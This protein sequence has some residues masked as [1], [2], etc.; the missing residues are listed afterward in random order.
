MLIDM[1]VHT[2]FSPCSSLGVE[3]ILDNA[4]SLG[5]DGVCLTD[6]NSLEVGKHLREGVQ[7]DGLVVL[8]GQE[9]ATPSGDFL[10][11][12]PGRA[13]P[14]GLRA[15]QLLQYVTASGGA[16]VAAHPFRRQRPCDSRVLHHPGIAA[17]E[18]INGRC[19]MDENLRALSWSSPRQMPVTGGS[20]AHSLEELARAV[21]VFEHPVRSQDE[22]VRALNSGAFEA[23]QLHDDLVP[24]ACPAPAPLLHP[25]QALLA[26]ASN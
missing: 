6:H 9:Y 17:I 11:F 20:D 1:H 21:T 8:V 14:A 22:L 7:A 26:A 10:L 2:D 13:A 12:G 15:K 19:T 16:A 24:R 25:H 4:R 3:S 18:G 5:L 23:L